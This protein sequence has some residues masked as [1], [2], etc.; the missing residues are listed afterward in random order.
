[1]AKTVK[2]IFVENDL[3]SFKDY[4]DKKWFK[5]ASDL[6]V[7]TTMEPV[8][9]KFAPHWWGSARAFILPWLLV[10]GAYDGVNSVVPTRR[11]RQDIWNDY[12][13]LAGFQGGLWKLAESM[14]CTIYYAYENLIVNCLIE[15]KQTQIRVTD[16]QFNKMLIDVYGDKVANKIWNGSFVSVSREIRNCI[17]HNGG[18]SSTNLLKM[19]PLPDIKNGDILISASD[20]RNLY[21]KLKPLVSDILIHSLEKIK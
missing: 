15:I 12:I 19:K 13:A 11:S 2:T 8:F 6:V 16:G 7:G 21:E 3:N 5:D 14:F 4:H 1:M 9:N 17:V 18:K 20:T 10:N